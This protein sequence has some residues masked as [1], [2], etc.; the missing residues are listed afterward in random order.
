[1]FSINP[2]ISAPVIGV[3]NILYRDIADIDLF[4]NSKVAALSPVQ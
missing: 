2:H 4:I 1:V 3:P